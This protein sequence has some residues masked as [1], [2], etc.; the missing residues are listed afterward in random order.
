M[1]KTD[2]KASILNSDRLILVD[3]YADWC[4]PCQSMERI[5]EES[6]AEL[7]KPIEV[8]KINID[9]NKQAAL[10]FSVR[11]IPH[12]ILFR[13]GKILW[14]KGGIVTKRDLIKNL[15]GFI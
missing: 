8:V 1:A 6:L 9:R 5:I 10:S 4:A 11:S 15:K 14:Q 7:N 13:K 3:F 12:L 2:F